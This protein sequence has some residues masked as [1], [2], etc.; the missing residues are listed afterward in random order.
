MEDLNKLNPKKIKKYQSS[1]ETFLDKLRVGS[2][3]N[4]K[5]THVSMGEHFTGK[6]MLD[7]K[8]SKELIKMYSEAIEYGITFNIAEKPKDYGPLI[9]DIDFELPI[10][11]YKEGTRLYNNKMIFEI[12]N[13][14]REVARE[15]LDL[16]SK[17]LVASVFEK[18]KPTIKISTVKDGIHI[19]FH[20]ITAHFKLRY[21]IR[22]HVVK[23]LTDNSLFTGFT[24]S[25]NDIIDKAVV[26]TNCWLLPGSKKKDGQLYELKTIYDDQ[27]I[28]IDITKT[29]QDKYKMIRLYSLQDKLRSEENSSTYLEDVSIEDIEEEY[30]KICEKPHNNT[31]NYSD[32]PVS[33]N[34]EDEIRRAKFLVSLLSDNRNDSFESWIKIGW[35]LHNIDPS[36]L[37]TW[38]EYSKRSSKFKEGECE[39]KW[40]RMRDEGLTIRSLMY[41][42]EED[43]YQ[44]Y[45][46]FIKQEF[47]EV[48][49]K[50][51]DGSTYFVAKA[52]HTKF[53]EKFICASMK[54]NL[55][56]EFRNHKWVPVHD[57]YTL[58]K[59]ISESFVNE[60][61]Q[62]VSKFS[63]KSTKLTGVEKDEAQQK[64]SRI[65]KI[66]EKLMNIS[67][68][69]KIMKEATILFFDPE[70]EKKLDENYD[71]IAF[72]NGVYDLLNSEFREGRP[73][74]YL[75]RS[76]NVDYHPFT[77][78]NVYTEKMFKFFRE[79]L[80]NEAVRKYLLLSL[81]TCVAG[82][83]KE[84]KC[85][86]VTGSGSN[87]KSLLFSLVQQALGDYYISC[88]I[89]IITR[90]RNS[91]N[92][93]SPELLRMKGVRCGCFQET[94]DGEKLNVGI[95]KEITGND[96]F[97]V[98]GLYSDPIEIKPQVKFFLACNQLPEVP[99][100]DGG[101]WRRLR[102]VDFKSKFTE[103]PVKQNEFLIDN[104]LK[105]KIKEWAPLFA[106][107]M[108]HLYINEYKTMSYL[109]EPDEVKYSTENYKAENDHYAEYFV[110]R[111]IV[112]GK[113]SDSIN[114]KTMYEDFK[115]WFKGSRDGGRVPAQVELNKYM[116]ERLGEPKSNK[117]K[118]YTFNNNDDDQDKEGDS[119]DDNEE[120]SSLDC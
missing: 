101:T 39:E 18:P 66:V 16:E 118:G 55:W 103:N 104:T 68:K 12:I 59:E 65:Q 75:S 56:Y 25:I 34:K 1:V 99:S 19:I 109:T 10:E 54:S 88:P 73:D 43:N 81:A 93:A 57:G 40:Y 105:Q 80:P 14:Y 46:E 84:E 89:T 78:N 63:I 97:M 119:D 120:K 21:L 45:H 4:I 67:F 60:Y 79:I 23:R 115:S 86:I 3:Q 113:K 11:D 70:F 29:L 83:N 71:L 26:N 102:V 30:S 90:K 52:L 24:K 36:L 100:T 9:I 22:N 27:N 28:S 44:K 95:L 108:I 106:S 87:G 50:S 53:M 117:W 5:Y 96:S 107:Y 91:S 6:F 31:N 42:A 48:L 33:E 74:D 112:T 7:K 13:S 69:E 111:I 37:S 47:A 116:Y 62:L 17:E 64:V 110:R 15:Y 85:R 49:N 61:S 98:R 94:D 77:E 82:H 72:N 76:T 51:L 38:I 58:K 8:Q 41:W 20:G 114:V 92:S 32:K 35:A 2:G